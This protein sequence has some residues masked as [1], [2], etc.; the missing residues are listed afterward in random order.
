MNKRS[1][2][3]A[4]RIRFELAG[5]TANTEAVCYVLTPG[6]AVIIGRDKDCTIVVGA[7]SPGAE[8]SRL[9]SR[10]HA[11]LEDIPGRGWCIHDNGSRNG[12]A[13]L[14]AGRLPG[15]VLNPGVDHQLEKDDVIEL[16]G[17]DDYQFVF[18][19]VRSP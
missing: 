5:M 19:P 4:E 17:S 11:V 13:V 10:Q 16:A 9:I 12:T 3:T 18:R 14:R 2:E 15:L 1:G 7:H 8:S 6:E